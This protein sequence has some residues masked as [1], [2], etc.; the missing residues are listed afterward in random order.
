MSTELSPKVSVIVPIYKTPLNYF[1]ECIKSLYNQSMREAEFILIFDG[2][3]KELLSVCEAYKEKD[4]RFKIF[5]QPHLGVSATRNYGITHAKG[6]YITFVDA[7][8]WIEKNCCQATYDFAKQNNSDIALFDYKP[9]A[10]QNETKKY[11]R[12]PISKFSSDEIQTLQEQTIALT[13]PKYVAAVSTWG[14]II[15]NETIRSNDIS[16]SI[17]LHIAVDRPFMFKVYLCAKNISYIHEDFYN[18]NKVK[19][20]ISNKKYYNKSIDLLNYLIEI[21]NISN[22]FPQQIGKQSFI[23]LE[24]AWNSFYFNKKDNQSYLRDINYLCGITRS[25]SFQNLIS[26]AALKDFHFI[27]KLE[28]FLIKHKI[29]LLFWIRAFKRTLF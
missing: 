13:D 17:N 11:A 26:Q 19:D 14:K 15:K 25:Q 10:G 6:E 16:F 29:T 5:I 1:K 4:S 8:D 28:L 24:D 3:N 20:S 12:S 23:L 22:K 21:Q 7:D 2:E 27:K 18:Y 9:V